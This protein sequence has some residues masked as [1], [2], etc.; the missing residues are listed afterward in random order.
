M[1]DG[2]RWYHDDVNVATIR[3]TNVYDSQIA[4][5]A[6]YPFTSKHSCSLASL[7][8]PS[9]DELQGVSPASWM[10]GRIPSL[11]DLGYG[12]VA[13]YFNFT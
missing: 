1:Q 12:D 10:R 4:H 6:F 11:V 5:I 13:H 3:R 8:L 7:L 2:E 9:P